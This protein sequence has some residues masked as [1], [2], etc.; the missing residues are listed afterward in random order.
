[1][2]PRAAL[3]ARLEVAGEHS[4]HREI[5]RGFLFATQPPQASDR[6]S[7]PALFDSSDTPSPPLL[8]RGG[9]GGCTS[10]H[11]SNVVRCK[12]TFFLGL[13]TTCMRPI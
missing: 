12:S 8:A 11:S 7:L 10:C 5:F 1:V 13:I 9:F 2:R 4:E 6:N 3:R